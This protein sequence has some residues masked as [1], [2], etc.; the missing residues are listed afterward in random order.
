MMQ[1][2]FDSL[3]DIAS[4][5][6]RRVM[7]KSLALTAAV[8]VLVWIGLDRLAL[9]FVAVNSSWLATLIAWLIGLGLVAGLVLLAAPVSSLVASFFF[10]EIAAHVEAEIDPQGATGRPAPIVDAT[11]AALRFGALTLLV[12]LVSLVLLFVPGVGL[13]A[14]LA[15][16][17]YLLGREYFEFAAM[18][19]HSAVEARALRR[20]NA[21]AVFVYGVLIAIFVAVPIVNLLTPLFATTL[22]VRLHRRVAGGQ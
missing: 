6:F 9:H 11:L 22:M 1:D 5:P 8:L 18:R 7:V 19:F 10:D 14:W 12:G 15:A 16:N 20:S 3:N 21:G 17:G 2:V 4:P 13:I